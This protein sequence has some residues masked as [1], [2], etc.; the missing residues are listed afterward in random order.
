[1]SVFERLSNSNSDKIVSLIKEIC[2][3]L[4]NFINAINN[5]EIKVPDDVLGRTYAEVL[6]SVLEAKM[7]TLEDIVLTNSELF[8]N[9]EFAQILINELLSLR[10]FFYGPN[11]PK[12]EETQNRVLKAVQQFLEKFQNIQLAIISLQN[13]NKLIKDQLEPAIDEVKEKVKDFESVRLALEQ[14]ETSSIYLDV[15]N[16]YKAEFK[17]NNLLFFVT[18]FSGA[19]IGI[20]STLYIEYFYNFIMNSRIIMETS[21]WVVFITTKIL[22][23]TIT[24]TLCTLFLRRSAHA[25]KM[26]EQAYQTHVEINAFPIHTRELSPDDRKE[27]IKELAL[28]Y[29]G[30]ELDQ[31]QNDKIGDLIQDQFTASTEMIKASAELVKVSKDLQPTK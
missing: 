28:K 4:D 9:N 17:S 25:K 29:F 15:H 12:K 22:I 8:N 30:K 24:I 11:D 26:Y 2:D 6:R 3:Y 19:I 5:Q 7:R 21:Y 1:M 13:A 14:R 18:L 16:K 10:G 27:L 31:K 23:L 20:Y